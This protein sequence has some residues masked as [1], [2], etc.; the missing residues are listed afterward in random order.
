M[1]QTLHQNIAREAYRLLAKRER[2]NRNSHARE[3]NGLPCT[4]S[5]KAAVQWCMRGAIMKCASDLMGIDGMSA[6]YLTLKM[7]EISGTDPLCVTNDRCSFRTMRATMRKIANT[8]FS[9]P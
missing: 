5:D 4:P 9:G 1:S 3:A 2:W 7:E 6:Y 8:D